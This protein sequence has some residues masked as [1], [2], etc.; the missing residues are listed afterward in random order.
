[1]PNYCSAYGFYSSSIK[2]P[3][4][5]FFSIPKRCQ[6]AYSM[7]MP[8]RPENFTPTSSSYVCSR[9]FTE[10]DLYV[11]ITD[12]PALFKKR[13][14]RQGAIP[15]VNL[16]GAPNEQVV[17][18]SVR[19]SSTLKSKA[20]AAAVE[21]E[22]IAEAN[23]Y[24][25]EQFSETSVLPKGNVSEITGDEAYNVKDLL[26]KITRLDKMRFCYKNLSDFDV[27]TY[28]GID[29][30]VFQGIVTTIEKFSPLNLWSGFPVK[31]ICLED[32]L[33]ILLLRLRLDLPYFDLASR[34]SVSETTIKNIV[35]IYL[36]A[37]H[38]IFF[39]GMMGELPSQEKNKYCLPGSFGDIT[40]CKIIIDCTEFRIASPR[41]D[42]AA[43]SA[44]YSNYK[45]Y[46]TAKYLIGVAPN[47]A[48]PFVSNGFP[49]G[50]SDKVITSDSGV[51]SHLQVSQMINV[52]N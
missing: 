35:M 14:L 26:E 11:P 19:L 47:G 48:I 43:A 4:F 20:A 29:R 6:V 7:G 1:M 22:C 30:S 27:K 16:Q 42:L 8:H 49:G 23:N 39:V 36:Y 33:L 12:T 50:V 21:E 5:M 3:R 46:L 37:M 15:S 18:R 10:A 31:S 38:E 9:H 44:S 40:T 2:E 51:I 34:Y 13:C 45:Q 28:T 24:A 25:A 17:K 32:Q 52:K 41:K